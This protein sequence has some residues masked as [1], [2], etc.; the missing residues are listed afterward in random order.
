[1]GSKK[2]NTKAKKKIN[3]IEKQGILS[4]AITI[5]NMESKHEGAFTVDRVIETYDKLVKKIIA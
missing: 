2:T 1:M 3:T 4:Q 5:V